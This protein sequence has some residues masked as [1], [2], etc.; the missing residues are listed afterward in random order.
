VIHALSIGLAWASLIFLCRI[1]WVD[2]MTLRI[3]NKDVLILLALVL[4]LWLVRSGGRDWIDLL[5]GGI[6]FVLGVVFWALR[7]MGAGDAKLFLPL[8]VMIGWSDLMLFAV[9][10]LPAT[11]LTLALFLGLRWIA[12]KTGLVGGRLQQIARLR[13]VPYAVPLFLAAIP[14]MVPQLGLS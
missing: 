9:A 12:P 14:A 13:G 6:L 5:A 7:M 8:G 2:F 3:R 1:A 11:L 4:V 10:L